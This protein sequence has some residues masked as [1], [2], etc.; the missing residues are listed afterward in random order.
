[1]EGIYEIYIDADM[2]AFLSYIFYF[3]ASS[4]SPLQRRWL[5]T[6]K[7]TDN[8]GQIHF[9]FQ[10]TFIIVILS[11]L[12][13]LFKPAYVS[14]NVFYLLGLSLLCGISG[15]GYFIS[16]FVSQRHIE[17]GATSLLLNINT[18]TAII[19]ATLFLNEGLTLIQILGTI[20]LLA[21]MIIVSKKHRM[22]RFTF[23]RFFWM[24]ALSGLMLGVLL[25]AERALQKITGFTTGTMLSWWTQC[26]FLG[27]A[28]LIMHDRST[29]STKD[30]TMTGGLRF[31]Q[32]LS[33]VI[34][35]TVVGNLS[36]VS[37]VTTFKVVIIFIAAAIFLKEREDLLRKIIGS[38]IAVGGLLLMK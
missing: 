25:A 4:A 11:L 37:A 9:S 38:F 20:F 13:P 24:M 18:P 35:L 27:L 10:V 3:A 14:G 36:F 17:A 23:D 34:L 28:T 30:I 5:A 12:L 6:K 32:S 15:A 1:M 8:T 29:Y 22:G 31:L 19:L 26:A 33:W 16:W 2:L 7:N 21:G